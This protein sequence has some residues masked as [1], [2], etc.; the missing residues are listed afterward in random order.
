MTKKKSVS[1]LKV[2]EDTSELVYDDGS[3]T[4]FK[5]GKPNQAA[6]ARL[7]NIKA[8]FTSGFLAKS[9]EESKTFKAP[10]GLTKEIINSCDELVD[11]VSQELGRALM[12]ISILQMAIKSI[13]PGQSIRLHKGGS[14]DF[15]WV[16]GISMRTLDSS[17]L[18]PFL[19]ANSLLSINSYGVFMT[20]GLAENYPYSK[21]YKAALRGPKKSW[22][23]V[24][25]F[26]EGN[27]SSSKD[28]LLYAL[29]KLS[30]RSSK[31]DEIVIETQKSLL[32]W[33]K[34]KPSMKSTESLVEKFLVNA[35]N[36]ARLLEICIHS[37]IYT[38]GDNYSNDLHLKPMTQMRSANKKAKNIGDI[39]LSEDESGNLIVESWDA[40]FG[41]HYYLDELDFLLE[42]LAAHP[43]CKR[44]GFITDKSYKPDRE[45]KDK[46]EYIREAFGVEVQILGLADW[47]KYAMDEA[48]A[49]PDSIAKDWVS[50]IHSYLALKLKDQAPIDE[51]TDRWLNALS[52]VLVSK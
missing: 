39:E 41:T 14:G 2:T 50:N 24:V 35:P 4:A 31:F 40:K 29:S 46:I 33:S 21:V 42:K 13:E 17:F 49:K 51:P 38:L 45:T 28:L 19:R 12:G 48:G 30:A 52:D 47:I 11:G 10:G 25:E 44:A 8:G 27:P 43:E 34:S 32:V 5:E 18:I 20:R 1:Y 6:I 3:T 15:S 7:A 26:L 22:L 36:A 23:E 37:F 16:D 9:L